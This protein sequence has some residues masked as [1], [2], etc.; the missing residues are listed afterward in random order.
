MDILYSALAG[1]I[2]GLTEFLPVSSSGHLVLLHDILKFDFS[3]N[4]LYDVAMHVATLV[5]LLLFFR[6]DVVRLIAAFVRSLRR[7]D[8]GKDPLERLAWLL[9][10]ATVPAVLVGYF[11]E[12]AVG[13]AL[14]RPVVV[15]VALAAV[16]V[17]FFVAERFAAKKRDLAGMTAADASTIGLAQALAFIPG[18]SRSGI[19]LV[20]G[21]GRGFRRE[22]AARFSFLLSIP[23]IFGAAVKKGLDVADWS[24][25][26]LSVLAVGF[27]VAFLSGILAIR[28]FMRF[29][30]RHPLDVFAWYRLALSAILVVW[31]LAGR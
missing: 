1:L 9:I 6:K 27:F 17:F 7:R 21:L 10:L 26:D 16:A 3:D 2:Q 19:T 4:V 23:T 24:A 29:V 25:A 11:L 14:R 20:A 30:R 28:F 31:L 18:V 13:D 15:A 8:F 22:E 5:A 12:S